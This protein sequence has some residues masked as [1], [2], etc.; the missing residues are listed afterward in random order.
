MY[1]TPSLREFPLEF[2]KVVVAPNRR[3]REFVDTRIHLDTI[4]EC[5]KQ[6]DR[7]TDRGAD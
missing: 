6:T 7:Q 4:P 5:D 1:L 2:C 3:W